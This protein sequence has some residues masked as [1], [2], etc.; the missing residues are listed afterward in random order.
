VPGEAVDAAATSSPPSS[1][2]T[3]TSVPAGATV[4]A[5]AEPPA[6]ADVEMVEVP[7]PPG[8]FGSGHP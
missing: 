1:S 3:P 5:P 8:S 6:A 4:G 2:L 7:P